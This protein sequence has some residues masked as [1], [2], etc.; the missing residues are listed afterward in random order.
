MRLTEKERAAIVRA[1][2]DA[3][4]PGTAVFLFGSRVDDAR[5]GGDID[6]LVEAPRPLS[7][8]DLVARR[9]RFVASIYYALEEQPIDVVITAKGTDDDRPVVMHA[10]RTGALLGRT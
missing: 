5:R 3:F 9:T 1:A 2:H 8:A 6:L 7:A 10:R 4:E